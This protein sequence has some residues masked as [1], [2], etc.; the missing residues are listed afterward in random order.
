M[1]DIWFRTDVSEVKSIS[2]A[3][4]EFDP[5]RMIAF[6]KLRPQAQK[7]TEP[8]GH[9]SPIRRALGANPRFSSRSIRK[10][11]KMRRMPMVE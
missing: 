9:F 1:A 5:A 7:Q 2:E 10:D 3:G 11:W 4:S 6:R 8:D